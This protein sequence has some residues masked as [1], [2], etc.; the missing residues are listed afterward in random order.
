MDS[1]GYEWLAHTYGVTPVQDFAVRC[2]TG[3]ARVTHVDA[4]DG[5]RREVY[6]ESYRPAPTFRAH[7]AFAFRYQGVHLEFL[8]RLFRLEASKPELEQWIAAEPTGAYAR[9]ACFFYEWL[10]GQA[11]SAPELSSGNYANALDPADYLVGRTV[12]NSRWRV[13]DNLPGT[14]DF[15]P[16]IRRVTSVQAAEQYDMAAKLSE[17]EHDFGI[18]L[19]MRSAV[20]LTVK[21]SR[22]SFLIERE[23]D[24]TE[25]IQRF[26]AVMETESGRH[27]NPFEPD[28]LLLL[29]RGILGERA[30][31]YGLRRSPVYVGH[32]ERYRAVVDYIA[33]H[34]RETAAMLDGLSAFLDRTGGRSSLIR[35]AVACFGFV[36]IHPMADGNG[37]ISRFLINDILRRDHATA[38]PIILPVSATITHS[39]Q[40]K[41]AYD[42]VLER[43]SRPLMRRYAEHYRFGA[44]EIAEDGVEYNFHFDG[45]DDALPVWRYPDLT[46]HVGYLAS[47]IDETLSNEMR[48][49]ARFLQAHDTA[50]AAIKHYLEAPDHDLDNI[51]RSVRQNN[52]QLSNSLCKRYPLLAGQ[53][54]VAAQIV[55]AIVHAFDGTP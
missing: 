14:P 31:R 4:D 44:T 17:L 27:A 11:L 48:S 18:D 55:A 38:A 37:R 21:E 26:A 7:L 2:A 36:Y 45:Y 33:P 53:T 50:R 9:R 43:I 6:P 1:I 8:T 30:L 34:W 28:T 13:N 54:D 16:L 24:K 41:A 22:A 49:E 52:N 12:R 19:L 42:Q 25:R 40:N 47:V 20:W 39:T 15:C 35:A 51:I 3:R 5:Q 10:T 46:A 32:T 23:Q 29:Q